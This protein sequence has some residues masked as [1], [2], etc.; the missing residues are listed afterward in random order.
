MKTARGWLWLVPV[1]AQHGAVGALTALIVVE[2]WA[3][4]LVAAFVMQ[5]LWWQNMGERID[6]HGSR[7]A[8]LAYCVVSA[9]GITTGAWWWR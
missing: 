3:G 2:A 6:R 4:V 5:W 7:W 8:A 1:F 9:L